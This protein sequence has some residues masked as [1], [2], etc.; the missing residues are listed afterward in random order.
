MD[1]LGLSGII[2]DYFGLSETIADYLGL[3]RTISDYMGL[4]G[5]IWDHLGLSGT[6]WHYLGLFQTRV[7]VEAGES[8]LLLFETF[9]LFFFYYYFLPERFLEELALLK[10]M[11]H[12]KY[13][14][15]NDTS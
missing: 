12:T 8:K 13:K 15:N 9:S 5:T 4:S 2:W 14:D 7:Q 1:Y 6:I 11:Y 3:S 10:E